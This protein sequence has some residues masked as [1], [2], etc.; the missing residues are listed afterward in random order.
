MWWLIIGRWLRK[1]I[2][3]KTLMIGLICVTLL[4]QGVNL[5]KAIERSQALRVF[6]LDVGQGDAILVKTPDNLTILIDTG[7]SESVL[8]ALEKFVYPKRLDFIVISHADADHI[9]GL[10]A[11]SKYYNIGMVAM[12]D[13]RSALSSAIA[14]SLNSQQVPIR[15]LKYA[16]SLQLG[17]CVKLKTLWPTPEALKDLRIS[18][19]D[20]SY[21]FLLTY[22]SQNIWFSGD[23]GSMQEKLIANKYD[24]PLV[25]IYKAGH[26]GSKTSSSQELLSEIKP[27]HTVISAGRDNSYGHP[28]A[29]VMRRI[30]DHGSQIW[31]TDV[32]GS[33]VFEYSLAGWSIQ[34][35]PP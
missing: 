3:K 2:S 34:T 15:Q 4:T 27:Q 28:H 35:F 14:D 9:E 13:D 23:L 29:D 33:I 12:Q 1:I 20:R 22:L 19:N 11:L 21:S 32:Q 7:R 31:R 25:A 16:G 26:H 6:F 18:T 24:L 10:L 8:P 5:T 30:N 17:C